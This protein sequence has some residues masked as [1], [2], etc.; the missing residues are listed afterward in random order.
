[1]CIRDRSYSVRTSAAA[2]ARGSVRTALPQPLMLHDLYDVAGQQQQQ[3]AE[4]AVIGAD[5]A[6]TSARHAATTH[7][8]SNYKH[9]RLI[10]FG[11]R[12]EYTTT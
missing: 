9:A 4:L 3:R 12:S 11:H 2:T 7:D 5:D 6:V 10:V 1:M 8:E